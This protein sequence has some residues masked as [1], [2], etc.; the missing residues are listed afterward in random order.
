MKPM[1][2]QEALSS[3]LALSLEPEHSNT[4]L[5]VLTSECLEDYFEHGEISC[6]GHT[7]PKMGVVWSQPEVNGSDPLIPK[8]MIAKA[9][10]YNVGSNHREQNRGI[11]KN[12]HR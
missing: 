12:Q 10:M 1:R 5:C 3:S 2:P 7:T 6:I 8:D 4:K 11:N 9:E